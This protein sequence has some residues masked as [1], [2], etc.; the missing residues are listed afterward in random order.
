MCVVIAKPSGSKLDL[1]TLHKCWNSNNQGAGV[2]WCDRGKIYIEKGFMEWDSFKGF[3]E[4]RD[5]TKIPAIV[6][7]RIATH[8]GINEENTH[9]FWVF[10]NQLAFAHNGMMDFTKEFTAISDTQV[11][12]RYIQ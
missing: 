12:N 7:F 5:W 2:A 9:P 6:H 4:S 11:F 1:T 8:G 3:W 10:P